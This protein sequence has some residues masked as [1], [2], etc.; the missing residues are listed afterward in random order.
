MPARTPA[1]RTQQTPVSNQQGN[2][3]LSPCSYGN[4]TVRTMSRVSTSKSGVRPVA[5]HASLERHMQRFLEL[6]RDLEKVEYFCKGTVLKRMMKCGK[7]Q[8]A[9]ASDATKRHGPYFEITY[10]AN[11]KTVNLKLSPEAAPLY[12]AAAQQYRK[13]KTLLNR[14]D[15]LSKTILRYQAKLAESERKD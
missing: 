11:G 9:C 1:V 2:T 14:L 5:R 15:K 4:M 6:R 8:C 12:R 13:L 7:P 10:K 3:L